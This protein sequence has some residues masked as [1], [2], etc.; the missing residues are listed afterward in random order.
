MI[1]EDSADEIAASIT[2]LAGRL[3]KEIA[4]T[5]SG[6]AVALAGNGL[7]SPI[8]DVINNLAGAVERLA[9]AIESAA[10]VP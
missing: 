8:G 1:D 4:E 6:V 7:R 9:E 10:R 5:G 2:Y 3:S